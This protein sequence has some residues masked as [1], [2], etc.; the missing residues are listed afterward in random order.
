MMAVTA[1]E[2]MSLCR[3]VFGA[4]MISHETAEAVLVRKASRAYLDCD[5]LHVIAVAFLLLQQIHCIFLLSLTVL[6]QSLS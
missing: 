6:P 1:T 4:P 5:Q 2:P 3:S